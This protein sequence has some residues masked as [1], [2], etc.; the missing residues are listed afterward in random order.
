[1]FLHDNYELIDFGGGRK[2]ERFADI[3]LDRPCRPA[4]G[5]QFGVPKAWTSARGRYVES[6]SGSER[7]RWEWMGPAVDEW[8]LDHYKLKFAL[9]CTPFGHVGLF[10]EQAA[11]WDW[12]ADCVTAARRPLDVLNLFAYTGGATLAAAAAG[13][14][15]VHVDAARNVVA[16]ARRNAEL[17]GLEKSPIRWIADDALAFVRREVR[18]GRQYDAVILDPPTYGHGPRGQPWKIDSQLG[19]LLAECRKLMSDPAFV[20]FTC[21]TP[22]IDRQAA[23]GWLT[24]LL[25]SSVAGRVESMELTLTSSTGR[26]LAAGVA[27]RWRKS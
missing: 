24:A 18:R 20:L 1:M 10:P 26:R 7:G 6:Y 22:A 4:E 23:A 13:A 17:S 21:H 27:A 14:S 8:M 16:W 11:N 3:V 19:D 15:V 9:H 2:L 5:A 12:I 25:P